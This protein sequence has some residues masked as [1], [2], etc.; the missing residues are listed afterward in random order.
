MCGVHLPPASDLLTIPERASRCTPRPVGEST[1]LSPEGV[2]AAPP[3]GETPTVLVAAVCG[4]VQEIVAAAK[5]DWAAGSAGSCVAL[6]LGG[7]M[8]AFAACCAPA[9]PSSA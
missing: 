8:A 5:F 6:E 3:G 2:A 9:M 4:G 1:S 7:V